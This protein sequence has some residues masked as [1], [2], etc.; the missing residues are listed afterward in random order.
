MENFV[1]SDLTE[2]NWYPDGSYL[3]SSPLPFVPLF[4]QL[5]GWRVMAVEEIQTLIQ[6]MGTRFLMYYPNLLTY[7]AQDSGFFPTFVSES[8]FPFR[9][10]TSRCEHFFYHKYWCIQEPSPSP[11]PNHIHISLFSKILMWSGLQHG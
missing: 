1:H 11:Q 8:V 9:G 10:H 5:G 3:L 7:C 6:K 4:R 2:P